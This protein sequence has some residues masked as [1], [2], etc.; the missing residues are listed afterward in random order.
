MSLSL[1][2]GVGVVG[3]LTLG[4]EPRHWVAAA[5]MWAVGIAAPLVHHFWGRHHTV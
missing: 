3:V 1:G 5:I 4:Q 2:A